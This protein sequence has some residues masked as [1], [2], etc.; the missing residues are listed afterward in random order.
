MAAANR[1]I[2]L[3]FIF[4][5][6]IS[7]AAFEI[8]CNCFVVVVSPAKPFAADFRFDRAVASC[9]IFEDGSLDVA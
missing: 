7:F 5:L 1:W 2:L 9:A 3:E 4:V 6:L 8:A